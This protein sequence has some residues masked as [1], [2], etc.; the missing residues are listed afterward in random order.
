MVVRLRLRLSNSQNGPIHFKD[1]DLLRLRLSTSRAF[2]HIGQQL[3]A[4]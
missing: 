4:I 2:G 3:G 1:L